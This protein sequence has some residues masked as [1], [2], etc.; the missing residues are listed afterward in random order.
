MEDYGDFEALC[1]ER[2]PN[3]V[4]TSRGGS[5][6]D[7]IVSNVQSAVVEEIILILETWAQTL[8]EAQQMPKFQNST[9]PRDWQVAQSHV[10]ELISEIRQYHIRGVQGHHSTHT[11]TT[12]IEVISEQ[13]QRPAASRTDEQ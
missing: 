1:K 3:H 5:V 6:F 13:H 7:Y 10:A 8:H 11:G 4:L 12:S 2:F 9:P